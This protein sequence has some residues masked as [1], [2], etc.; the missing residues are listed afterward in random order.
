MGPAE[1]V[2]TW[3]DLKKQLEEHRR[4]RPSKLPQVQSSLIRRLC[5]IARLH[6]LCDPE[7]MGWFTSE[8][9]KLTVSPAAPATVGKWPAIPLRN[10]EHIDEALLTVS[11]T[12]DRI[13]VKGYSIQMLGK[14]RIAGTPPWYAR[15]DLDGVDEPANKGVGLCSHALLHTH[16]GTTPESDHLPSEDPLGKRKRF[17]TRVPTPW[18]EPV[19]AL[20]WLLATVDGRLEPVPNP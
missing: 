2:S 11:V 15:V 1:V 7:V 16:V 5:E 18:L 20:N 3:H 13:G 19:D 12:F 9:N 10:L 6:H 14:R 8:K 17:S 4:K